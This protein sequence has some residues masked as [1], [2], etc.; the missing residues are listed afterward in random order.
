METNDEILIYHATYGTAEQV[1][2][3]YAAF[4][5][6]QGEF[7]TIAKNREVEIPIKDKQTGARFGSYKFRYADLEEINSKT[8]KPLSANGLGTMQI[9]GKSTMQA[10]TSIFT[11]LT[12]AEGACIEAEIPL[13]PQDKRDIKDYGAAVSYLRRYAKSALLDIAADDDVDANG[14]GAIGDQQPTDDDNSQQQTAVTQTAEKPISAGKPA[15]PDEKFKEMLPKWAALITSGE[16]S[17]DRVIAT[18]SSGNTLSEDQ[19]A[20]IRA[21]E[22]EEAQA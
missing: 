18:V 4:A 20:Q 9:I 12:H 17:A 13:P 15:Y 16:K 10:G 7:P 5:K 21:L 3:L 8:R 11:R 2:A 19:I 22:T 1:A 6:A 14:E